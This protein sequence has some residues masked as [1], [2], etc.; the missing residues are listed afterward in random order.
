MSTDM[1]QE[2]FA[3]L[4]PSLQAYRDALRVEGP[5]EGD[6]RVQLFEFTWTLNT[7]DA[8]YDQDHRGLWGA[9]SV[10]SEDDDQTIGQA[11][12]DAIS[13]VTFQASM[14]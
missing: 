7:G 1:Q 13:E 10:S 8:S 5:A 11:L 3:E 2:G 14:D 4:F 9:G 6:F 12:R